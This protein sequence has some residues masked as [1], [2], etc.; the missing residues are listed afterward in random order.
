MSQGIQHTYC[1]LTF[2]RQYVS[3]LQAILYQVLKLGVAL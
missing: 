2:R 3:M 1:E